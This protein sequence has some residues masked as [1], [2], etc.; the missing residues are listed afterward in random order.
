MNRK[1]IYLCKERKEYFYIS[2]D[3]CATAVDHT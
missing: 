2:G 3:V 1:E